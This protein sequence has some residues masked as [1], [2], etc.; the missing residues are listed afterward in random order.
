MAQKNSII[1]IA[2]IGPESTAKS[3]LSEALAKYYHTVWIPE[4][5]RNYLNGLDRKYTLE[6]VIKIA[7]EQL[8]QEQKKLPSANKLIFADTE[9]IISK[10]WC[11]E[12]FNTSPEWISKN[13]L[14]FKYDLYLL[15]SPDLTWET[16]PLR[17]NPHRRKYLFDRY[18]SEL[19]TIQANYKIINGTGDIRLKNCIA[20]IDLFVK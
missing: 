1:R 20:E 14:E 10:I 12:V 18:E 9:L 7:K 8:S 3:T 13:I 16:D 4:Y 11:E 5:A 15:T 17:E 19:K 2:L 6:D